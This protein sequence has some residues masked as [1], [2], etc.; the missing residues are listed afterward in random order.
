M[1]TNVPNILGSLSKIIN[2]T[3][4]AIIDSNIAS[5]VSDVLSTLVSSSLEVVEDTLKNVQELTKTEEATESEEPS[6]SEE[7]TET[8]ESS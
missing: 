7:S 6:E 8:E 5:K 3:T 1:P 2:Q 4:T